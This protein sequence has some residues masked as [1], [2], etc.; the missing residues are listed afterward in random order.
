MHIAECPVGH[1]KVLFFLHIQSTFKCRYMNLRAVLF[2]VGSLLFLA[3]NL[4]YLISKPDTQAYVSIVTPAFNA[5]DC[6]VIIVAVVQCL[7]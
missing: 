6:N 5:K 7:H 2:A 1:K 3:Q 4:F